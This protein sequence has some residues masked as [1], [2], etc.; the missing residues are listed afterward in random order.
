M[1]N[2]IACILIIIGI[3]P[4]IY[5]QNCEA[6]YGKLTQEEF[7]TKMLTWDP[8]AEAVVLFDFGISKFVE[9][10][11]DIEIRFERTTRIKI[12]SDA[13]LGFANV[14]IPFYHDKNGVEIVDNLQANV[15]NRENGYTIKTT[16][17]KVDFFDEKINDRITVR[18]F[19]IPN[20]KEGSVIEYKYILTSPFKFNLQDWYFQWKIPVLYSEYLV[21]M[22]PFYEYHFVV[23]GVSKLDVYESFVDGGLARQIGS[24]KFN[25]MVHRYVL[26]NIPAFRDEEFISS[27]D[28]YLIKIDFQLSQINT[29]SG[30]KIRIITSWPEL[31]KSLLKDEQFG[32]YI[33]K[34]EKMA[35]KLLNVPELLQKDQ[36]ERFNLVVDYVKTNYK[37]DGNNNKFAYRKVNELV[38]KKLGNSAEINLFL[39]GLLRAVKIDVLPVISSTRQHGK[40]K[41]DFP[42]LDLFNYVLGVAYVDGKNILVDATDL[43]CPSNKIPYRCVND[44]GLIVKKDE[45]NWAG[46]QSNLASLIQTEIEIKVSDSIMKSE[47]KTFSTEYD[48]MLN[49]EKYGDDKDKIMSYLNKK[50]YDVDEESLSIENAAKINSPYLIKF[51]S[52][53]ATN[54]IG[55]KIYITPFL[56]EAIS[57]NPLKQPKSAYPVDMAFPKKRVC[58]STIQIPEGYKLDYKG[59]N[60]SF[61]NNTD[62]TVVVNLIYDFKNSIYPP[63]DYLKIK[64]YYD[65]IVGK[66][67][68]KIVFSKI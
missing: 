52:T 20:V 22:V 62:K 9:T 6:K 8:T 40:I 18:K 1:K 36:Q 46:L 29:M 14:E 55:N 50:S 51:K 48:A 7:D 65:E 45:V 44:K 38:E 5:S 39:I 28:D 4:H 30:A 47:I 63:E 17:D 61:Q 24:A 2:T 11:D 3:F 15:Y 23:Q 41:Y 34:S 43:N 21:K 67:K 59:E 33:D 42:F 25:D 13:G 58:I 49:R 64:Y 10:L 16:I 68:E 57:E 54:V 53:N 31:I 35:G 12:Y 60:L 27:I 56:S 66:A 19:A 32:K 37:W 26:K